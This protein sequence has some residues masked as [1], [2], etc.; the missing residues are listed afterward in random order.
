M[1]VTREFNVAVRQ[2][3]FHGRR[4]VF[5]WFP[6]TKFTS[7]SLRTVLHPRFPNAPIVVTQNMPRMIDM[8]QMSGVGGL[9]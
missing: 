5:F 7:R 1:T 3:Q 2:A 6:G 4:G 9:G 8:S